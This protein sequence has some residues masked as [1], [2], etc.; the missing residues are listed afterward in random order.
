MLLRADAED[1]VINLLRCGRAAAGRVDMQNDRLHIR[2]VPELV[3]LLV[4]SVRVQNDAG[5][6]DHRNRTAGKP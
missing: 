6:I 4:D 5:D 3:E 1:L 2:V